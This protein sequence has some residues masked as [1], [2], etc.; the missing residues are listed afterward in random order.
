MLAILNSSVASYFLNKK[1]NSVKLL[2]SHIESLPILMAD[3]KFQKEIE[4]KVDQIMDESKSDTTFLYNE[5]DNDIFSV[6]SLSLEQRDTI[7]K[8]LCDKT[9]FLK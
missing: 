4:K 9:T 7:K 6:Y 2:K 1:F 3:K 5:L 8:A